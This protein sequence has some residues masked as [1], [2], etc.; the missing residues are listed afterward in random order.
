MRPSSSPLGALALASLV[1]AGTIP[2]IASAQDGAGALAAPD[3]QATEPAEIAPDGEQGDPAEATERDRA[4]AGPSR[5]GIDGLPAPVEISQAALRSL[6]NLDVHELA[7]DRDRGSNDF[8]QLVAITLYVGG[9]ALSIAGVSLI[10]GVIFEAACVNGLVDECADGPA[11]VSAAIPVSVGAA[12]LLAG[13]TIIQ[14]R[15]DTWDRDLD[16]RE[17]ELEGERERREREVGLA[18]GPGSL[19][20]RIE[21]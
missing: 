6:A 12:V 8:D 16:A 21:L 13:A 10:V 9:V 4:E 11:F 2:A 7:L 3:P 15:V 20:L 18:I 5:S 19:G 1:W 14:R 17:R